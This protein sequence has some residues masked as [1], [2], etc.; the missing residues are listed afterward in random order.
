MRYH[1]TEWPSLKSPQIT[2][3]KEGLQKWEHFY[4]VSGNVIGVA[5]ME[6]STEFPQKPKN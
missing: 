6:I 5:I 2:N 3:A 1:L 4:P